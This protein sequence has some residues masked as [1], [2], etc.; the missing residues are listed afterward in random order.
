MPAGA[1]R[2][3]GARSAKLQIWRP[4][5]AATSLLNGD[6]ANLPDHHLASLTHSLIEPGLQHPRLQEDE[7]AAA[8]FDESFF[9][10][11]RKLA[12]HLLTPATDPRGQHMMEWRW[13]HRAFVRPTG[14]R[15]RHAQEF[16]VEPVF[17]IK[18]RMLG[19][20]GIELAHTSGQKPQNSFTRRWR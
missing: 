19:K 1:P 4:V 6:R 7:R 12:G 9:G 17:Q 10:H 3:R 15:M 18:D 16:R 5:A 8:F 20:S 11:R 14:A 2:F 13:C